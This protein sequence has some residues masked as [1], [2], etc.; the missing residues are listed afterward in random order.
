VVFQR[1][2][3]VFINCEL[4]RTTVGTFVSSVSQSNCRGK[5][6]RGSSRRALECSKSMTFVFKKQKNEFLD[7]VIVF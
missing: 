7:D 3:R 6:S 4:A 5:G 2:A 1:W